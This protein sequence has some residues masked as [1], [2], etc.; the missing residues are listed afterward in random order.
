LPK[1]SSKEEKEDKEDEE[2]GEYGLNSYNY[3]CRPIVSNLL[4]ADRPGGEGAQVYSMGSSN[5]QSIKAGL[6][7][8]TSAWFLSI[9][10]Y[11]FC[12]A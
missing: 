5:S 1:L 10:C 3:W 11:Y 8:P 4:A 6:P 12:G 9:L 7:S 2:G